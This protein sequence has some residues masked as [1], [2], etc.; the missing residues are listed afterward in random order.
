[1]RMDGHT[2]LVHTAAASQLGQMLVKICLTDNVP[3]VNVVR[4]QEQVEL[5]TA[6]GARHVVNSSLPSFAEDLA[7][8]IAEAEA[9]L[10]FD[11]TGG[12]ALAGQLLTAME[13]AANRN[14]V[15]FSRYGSTQHKQVCVRGRRGSG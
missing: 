13:V 12:G 2:A 7:T 3:L 11:A 9:F 15:G 4:R 6:I 8:A 10:A 1:M 5:L 14:A